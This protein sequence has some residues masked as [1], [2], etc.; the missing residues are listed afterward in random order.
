MQVGR[1]HLQLSAFRHDLADHALDVM[2]AVFLDG[3]AVKFIEVL[4][5]GPHVDV[6]HINIRIRILFAA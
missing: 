2:H 3:A 6:E 1:L 5:G 4:A